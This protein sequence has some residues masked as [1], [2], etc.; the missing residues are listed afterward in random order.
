MQYFM[1]DAFT[2]KLFSGN[3]AGVCVPETWPKDATMQSIA[4]ENNLSET[5]F[6]VKDGA[7]YDLRWFT[8]AVEIELC[9]HATLATAFVLANH[10]DTDVD[11]FEFHTLSGPLFVRRQDDLFELNFPV[12]TQEKIAVTDEMR[13]A[14]GKT[15]TPVLSAYGGYNLMLELADEAAVL[16]LVPD[17]EAIR[18]LRAYHGVIVT[19]AG[20]DCDFVSRFFAPNVGVD[21]DPVTGSTHTS[22]VPYW[23][24]RLGRDEL[25]ARQLSKRGGT[26]YCRNAGERVHISGHA[27]LYL[28]GTIHI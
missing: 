13:R 23:A 6:V 22:L 10:V 16:D 1:V 15:N 14:L 3:Q 12:R 18:R 7:H 21:E 11:A 8:P 26:L 24:A 9:G 27:R 4:A 25:T 5:A 17:I 20:S 28:S 2:D 19:A